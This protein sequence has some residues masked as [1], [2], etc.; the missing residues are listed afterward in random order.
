MVA[1]QY[2][3]QIT[4]GYRVFVL[5]NGISVLSNN[6]LRGNLNLSA[7]NSTQLALL[8]LQNNSITN[9]EESTGNDVDLK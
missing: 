9:L 4:E 2:L 5:T 1:S 8:D 3:L 7:I 6:Q